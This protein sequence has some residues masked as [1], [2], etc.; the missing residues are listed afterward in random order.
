MKN[1]HFSFSSTSFFNLWQKSGFSAFISHEK[2]IKSFINQQ[3]EKKNS[4]WYY[5]IIYKKSSLW[6]YDKSS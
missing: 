5:V 3:N 4:L 6:F 2:I 1:K